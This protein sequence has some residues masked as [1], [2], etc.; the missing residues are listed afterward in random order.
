VALS[1]LLASSRILAGQA[2]DAV[3]VEGRV[4]D[5]ETGGGVARATV[6]V[7][8]LGGP[9]SDQSVTD[10]QGAFV[11][12]GLTS[13]TLQI[14]VQHIAYG[15]STDTLSV[16]A[17]ELVT[18]EYR[19]SVQPIE[20]VGISV[21]ARARRAPAELARGTRVDGMTAAEVDAVRT[22]VS[23]MEDL[24]RL[25]RV[26]G[27]F[28]REQNGTL[29]V[30]RSRDRARLAGGCNMVTVVVDEVVQTDGAVAVTL[31]NPDWVDS[32]ELVPS[33]EAGVQYGLLSGNGVLK[34]QTRNGLRPP[35]GYE[36]IAQTGPRWALSAAF[37]A[38]GSS[39]LHDGVIRIQSEGGVAGLA[40]TERTSTSPGVE[41]AVRWNSRRWGFLGV[42]GYG[43]SG[44]S[45]AE[46][47]LGNRI[48]TVERDYSIAGVDLWW[49][50]PLMRR[51][52][53][54]ASLA[55][56]PSLAWQKLTVEGHPQELGDPGADPPPSVE[57]TD[58]SWFAPGA[59]FLG[60]LGY[61]FGPRSGVFLGLSIR[62]LSTSG[63]ESWAT[64]DQQAILDAT[65]NVVE[66]TYQ[67]GIAASFS[68]RT[69][70][71]WYP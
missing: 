41:L 63:T 35:Q 36:G 13:G 5:A 37:L 16:A 30:E 14:R 71:R 52:A 46:Y 67:G 22:R 11:F 40:Y 47:N 8:E 58:R 43:S 15:L 26:P 20:V 39:T 19:V 54:N 1:V 57:W 64:Q 49:G 66:L 68:L 61:D 53:W 28:I 3:R 23:S 27:L 17:G 32:W 4:L 42:T 31:L 12:D 6:Q 62:L 51:G 70:F 45:N 60:D 24:L 10:G 34:I 65:G 29:C 56:G 50:A 25:G 21:T 7:G 2:A 59:M 44:S 33:S 18:V 9:A 48:D 55:L 38:A 69:G